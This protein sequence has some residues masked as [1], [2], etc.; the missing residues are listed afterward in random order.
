MSEP[1][2]RACGI[3]DVK[4]GENVTVVQPV[5][6]Y[7]CAI[8]DESFVGPFVE[9]QRGA[10]IGKRTRIQSHAFI[11]DLVTIGDVPELA[12]Q[13]IR[14]CVAMCEDWNRELARKLSKDAVMIGIRHN[15]SSNTAGID[16]LVKR[17]ALQRN[18]IDKVSAVRSHEASRV[19]IRFNGRII[20]VPNAEIRSDSVE[21]ER[22]SHARD[23]RR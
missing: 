7:G 2:L 10:T 8:G 19:K 22:C 5:N 9:I 18:R 12:G 23:H 11:C 14:K 16:K 1:E 20:T 21:I 4:F 3:V 6:L 13:S 17:L 15:N